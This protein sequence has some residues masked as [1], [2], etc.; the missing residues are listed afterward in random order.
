M[1]SNIAALPHRHHPSQVVRVLMGD[2]KKCFTLVLSKSD[3]P[4]ITSS[5]ECCVM[6]MLLK[7]LSKFG[8]VLVLVV[9]S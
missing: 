4:P 6:F 3:L 7:P 9:L 1:I 5:V 2:V 8:F